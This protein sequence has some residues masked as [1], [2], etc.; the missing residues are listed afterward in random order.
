MVLQLTDLPIHTR[1]LSASVVF[2]RVPIH[3]LVL[4]IFCLSN[5][6][7]I[8]WLGR[9][10]C[11]PRPSTNN[12]SSPR[13]L[14]LRKTDGEGCGVALGVRILQGRNLVHAFFLSFWFQRQHSK[15]RKL[16]L[17][18]N[19]PLPLFCRLLLRFCLSEPPASSQ[20]RQEEVP[21]LP[22]TPT[23]SPLMRLSPFLK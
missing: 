1:V 3:L 22:T 14:L 16:L 21:S 9:Y 7:P 8:S 19:R 18:P 4:T 11:K 5:Y 2:K 20:D 12:Q 17:S 6:L 10:R 15:H 13:L 23:H